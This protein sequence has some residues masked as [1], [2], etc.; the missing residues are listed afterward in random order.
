MHIYLKS[1]GLVCL[2]V[3]DNVEDDW[4]RIVLS[5]TGHPIIT[6]LSDDV[7]IVKYHDRTD[8]LLIIFPPDSKEKAVCMN[9][10]NLPDTNK[11]RELI[12]AVFANLLD[13]N[14]GRLSNGKRNK[15]IIIV[16]SLLPDV[17]R[18]RIGN[19]EDGI[20]FYLYKNQISVYKDKSLKV[21]LRHYAFFSRNIKDSLL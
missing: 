5:P 4:N 20:T 3:P 19:K 18:N 7:T 11:R 8:G 16:R 17:V 14:D 10:H 2:T 12:H 15:A 1:G 21:K 6:T 9:L 13:Y